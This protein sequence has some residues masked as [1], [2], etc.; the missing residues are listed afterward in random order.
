MGMRCDPLAGQIQSSPGLPV[1]AL[2][3]ANHN[4][5]RSSSSLFGLLSVQPKHS[6]SSTASS[7]SKRGL[8]VPLLK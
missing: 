5:D 7:Y 4:I 6:A 3:G 8:L 2:R 1:P